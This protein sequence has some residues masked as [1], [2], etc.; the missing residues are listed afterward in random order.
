MGLN[1]VK[2]GKI[3]TRSSIDQ[4]HLHVINDVISIIMHHSSHKRLPKAKLK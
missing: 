2:L 1:I 3:E 4:D